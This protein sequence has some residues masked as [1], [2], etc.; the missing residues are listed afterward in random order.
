MK[1]EFIGKIMNNAIYGAPTNQG[2][3]TYKANVFTG[4]I[5][6]CRRGDENREWIANDGNVSGAWTLVA[7]A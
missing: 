7:N 2:A 6:R 4:E 1:K 3:Y 5:F